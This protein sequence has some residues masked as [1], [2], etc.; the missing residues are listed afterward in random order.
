[1]EFYPGARSIYYFAKKSNIKKIVSINH[2][3][4]FK[5]DL[6]Y[7][8]NSSDFSSKDFSNHYSPRPDI[9][10]CQGDK[11]YQK[12]IK[13]FGKNKVHKV[14]NLK[15]ELDNSLKIKNRNTRNKSKKELLIL[16]NINDYQPF[17]NILNKCDLSNFNIYVL[18]HP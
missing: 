12:L 10:M 5:N 13:I 15:V 17:I 16:C 11:Y 14:G 6:F 7:S 18:P 3:I 9:F 4:Y 2:A 8:F 1:M